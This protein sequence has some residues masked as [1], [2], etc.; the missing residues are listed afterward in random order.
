MPVGD[1][2]CVSYSLMYASAVPFIT[3]AFLPTHVMPS[4]VHA[5]PLFEY[6]ST[7]VCPSN[8]NFNPRL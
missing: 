4:A 7:H 3:T 1:E 5:I 6:R 8:E 2:F